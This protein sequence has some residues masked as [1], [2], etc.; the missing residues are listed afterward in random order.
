[1]KFSYQQFQNKANPKEVS[2]K[3]MVPIQ[4]SYEKK[5]IKLL[6]LIDSGADSCLFHKSIADALEIDY[7][8]G[9]P[10]NFSGISG[11]Q[12]KITAYFHRVHLTVQGLSSIDLPVGFTES[13]G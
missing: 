6:A 9:P 2:I 12:S 13:D 4:L 8:K 10:K 5:T 3:P 1:M 7:K 11:S